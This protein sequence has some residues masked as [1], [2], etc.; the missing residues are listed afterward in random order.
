MGLSGQAGV[1]RL[2]A[3]GREEVRPIM[4]SLS[5]VREQDS[6]DPQIQT[7]KEGP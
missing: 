4:L 7:R 5:R 1:Q 2:P 3:K 6:T